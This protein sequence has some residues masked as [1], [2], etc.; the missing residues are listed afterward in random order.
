M[1]FVVVL[2]IGSRAY[3][4]FLPYFV[5][6]YAGDTLWALMAFLV[7]GLIFPS[8]STVK[9]AAIALLF[10]VCIELSQLYHAPWID[11]IRE[12]RLG[13]LVLGHGFLWSDLVCYSVGVAMGVVGEMIMVGDLSESK[14]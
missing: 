8:L 11:E 6:T 7:I 13:A 9:V 14:L 1:P 2:G 12:Y 10:S 4:E 3:F 5:S